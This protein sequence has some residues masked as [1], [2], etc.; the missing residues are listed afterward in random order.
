MKNYEYKCVQ[1]HATIN[2]G[3]AGKSSHGKAIDYYEEILN[4]EAKGGWEFVEV[5]DIVS[6]Q[7]G[8]CLAGILTAKPDA[9]R[10]KLIIF[11]REI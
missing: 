6:T 4:K 2:V 11:K 9:V 10:L 8:G 7:T 3:K 5:D 1:V